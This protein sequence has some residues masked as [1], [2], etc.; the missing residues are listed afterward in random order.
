MSDVQNWS[1]TAGSNNSASPDGWPESMAPSGI[2][3]SARENMAAIARWYK[4]GNG[5]LASAGSSNAYTLAPNRT[6]AAYAAGVDF[7]FLANHANTGAATLNVNSLG[8]KD[9]RDRN[10]TALV[11]GEISQYTV[12][13]AT[14]DATN[15]YFRCHNLTAAAA[16][17]LP[18]A[19][20]TVQ[21]IV[22]LATAAETL[23]GSSSTLAVTPA[24]MAG[25][26]SLAAS[27]YYK[28][29]GGLIVQWGTASLGASTNT[30][31]TF[32]LAMTTAYSCVLTL[33]ENAS[34]ARYAPKIM[35]L[36]TSSVSVRNVES[37]TLACYYVA[38]GV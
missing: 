14:Y 8:A 35:S 32:P 1:T 27:G 15:G 25:N 10:G 36:G 22:E 4:D 21:G 24:S 20:D 3:N 2:N 6:I 26:K 30:T 16:T 11:G 13:Q 31:I 28:L 33:V 5:S 18:S 23:T 34:T 19:S 12:V 29:P 17:S 9:L 37:A 7:V 38:M